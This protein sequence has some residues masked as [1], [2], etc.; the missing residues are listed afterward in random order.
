MSFAYEVGTHR[1]ISDAAV[2]KSVLAEPEN[3]SR[4]GLRP[5]GPDDRRQEFP[6]G[7]DGLTSQLTIRRLFRFGAGWED[8]RSSLQA[9]RHFYDPV[10]DRALDLTETIGTSLSIKSPDW[11]I[12]D[13]GTFV[14]P[15]HQPYSYRDARQYFYEALTSTISDGYRKKQFGLTFQTLGNVIHHLQ[16]MAQPQHVRNDPHCDRDGCKALAVATGSA[17]LFSPSMYEAYTDL[18][19]P[20]DPTKQIRSRLPY[21]GAGSTP[22]YPGANIA[23]NP[24]KAPRH[25]WRTTAPGTDIVPGKGIAE[26]TNRNFFSAASIGTYALPPPPLYEDYFQPT[27]T[28]DI[29][30]LIPGTTITGRMRFW[31]NPVGDSLAGGP[32]A[33]NTRALTEGVL[34][35]DLAKYYNATSPSGR[36]A[37]ALNR[38]TYDAAHQFLVPRAVAY[39]AGLINYFFRGQLEISAPDEGVYGI[40]DHYAHGQRNSGG[41]R[42]IKVKVRNVTPGGTDANGQPLIEPIPEGVGTLVAVVKYHYNNCYQADLSGEYGSPGILWQHCRLPEE[43]IVVSDPVPAPAGI[44]QQP[45]PLTFTFAGKVPIEATDLF[46]QVVYRGPLGEE[47]DAV[48]VATKDISEPTYIVQFVTADQYLYCANGVLSGTSCQGSFTFKESFCDQLHPE[49]SLDQCKARYGLALKF[50][51]SPVAQPVPGYDPAAPAYPSGQWFPVASEPPFSPVATL[52]AGVGSLAR[53]AVLVDLPPP[54]PTLVVL[55][56]GVGAM[57]TSFMWLTGNLSPTINQIDPGSG[58][59]TINRSYALARGAYVD[60]S[61]DLTL[62]DYA[63]L[64]AGNASNIPFLVLAPSQVAF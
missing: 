38:F 16:D 42:T 25:F 18:D 26:Y 19:H 27:E 39:S 36:P 22:V 33:L 64:T 54:D 52:P 45:Q 21:G 61:G 14:V 60:S 30:T 15:A 6:G 24:F 11:A 7:I 34:D 53:V 58:A 43:Y 13:A 55:E 46:L 8:D 47:S 37:Y 51:P 12:E 57:A 10:N 48:V 56:E 62:S 41:F 50:R 32:G 49:L 44:N 17:Q 35:S 28:V 63:K 59:M 3:L 40:L 2:D 9:L 20:T 29:A 4:L 23:T 1:E 31:G 5:L